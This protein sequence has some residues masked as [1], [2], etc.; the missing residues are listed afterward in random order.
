MPCVVTQ[1]VLFLACNQRLAHRKCLTVMKWR[2]HV[3][4]CH[5]QKLTPKNKD[6]LGNRICSAPL[7]HYERSA[8][9]SQMCEKKQN[10]TSCS[11][12]TWC[13]KWVLFVSCMHRFREMHCSIYSPVFIR[14]TNSQ[15]ALETRQEIPC[16]LSKTSAPFPHLMLECVQFLWFCRRMTAT[17]QMT[18]WCLGT[19]FSYPEIQL[20]KHRWCHSVTKYASTH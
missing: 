11:Y 4:Q 5:K 16:N 10:K 14:Q 2:W 17:E 20:W 15:V 1:K 3:K 12:L 9:F 13:E 8:V 6:L 19:F 18:N 7:W